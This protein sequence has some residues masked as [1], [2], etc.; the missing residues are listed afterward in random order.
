MLASGARIGSFEIIEPIGSGGMG[1]V[2]RARDTRLDRQVAIKILPARYSS[3]PEYRL[4]LEREAK[5]IARVNHPNICTIHDIGQQDDVVYLVFECLEGASLEAHLDR[6]PMA[7]LQLLAITIEITDALAAAHGKGVIHRDI[8]PANIFITNSGHAKILDFG[9]AKYGTPAATASVATELFG[10][11]TGTTVGTAGYM[12]PEQVLG[13]DVD[14]RSDIFSLGIVLYRASTGAIPFPGKTAGEISDAILHR[15]VVRPAH[16]N[17]T[18]P[19]EFE[20]MIL[21]ALEKDPDLRYQSAAEMRADV[22]R[23]KRDSESALEIPIGPEKGAALPKASWRWAAALVMVGVVVLAITLLFVN[24]LR[25]PRHLRPIAE[26]QLTANPAEMP[27]YT[28]SISADGKHLA[29]SDSSGFYI[30]LLETG[31]TNP[32]KLPAGFCFR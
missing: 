12:S 4:R 2:Y 30:R 1:E 23:V 17:A 11:N 32:L 28:A 7:A 27:V 26:R 15:A 8:K 25:A 16:L 3:D 6:A 14:P 13:H 24:K 31:E 5:V 10:T 29:Y 21:K 9:L 18:I 20:Q 22:R 19:P